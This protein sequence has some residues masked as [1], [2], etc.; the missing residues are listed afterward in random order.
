M[1]L[2]YKLKTINLSIN[3]SIYKQ[4]FVILASQGRLANLITSI[5]PA[6]FVQRLRVPEVG[7]QREPIWA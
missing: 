6:N 1:I 3:F 4:F 7:D 5:G 2:N